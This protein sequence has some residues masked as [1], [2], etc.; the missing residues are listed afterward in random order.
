MVDWRGLGNPSQQID[1][2]M[3]AQSSQ[4]IAQNRLRLKATIESVRLLASQGMAFRG[5]DESHDS[6]NRG[7]FIE[8][9]KLMGRCNIDIDNVVL[10][11]APGNAKYIASSIQKEILHIFANK[12]RKLIREEVGNSKYCILVD[13]AVDEA[14]KEQMAIILR[15]VDCHGFIRERFFDMV[16]V[17]DIRALT[18]K[19]EITTVL[20]QH[21][22]LVENLRGQGYDGASNMRGA[23]NGLQALFF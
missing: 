11:N 12:V 14:N 20:G 3:N 13:E 23:W 1:T 21:E 5:N 19:N 10:D 18:L 15:Y 8:V 9:I 22:L 17:L 6:S 7:N 4:Q 2:V 16:S